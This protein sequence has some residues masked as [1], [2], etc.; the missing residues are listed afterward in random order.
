MADLSTY[1]G[2]C[3]AVA[4]WLGRRDLSEQIPTF[5]QLAERRMNRELRLR[6]M[7]RRAETEVSAGQQAVALPLRREAGAWDVFLEMRDLVW[8]DSDGRTHDLRYQPPDAYAVSREPGR[9]L[10]YSIVGRELFLIPAPDAAGSLLMSYYAELEPLGEQTP[11]N[12]LLRQ[13]PDIYLY[14]ALMEAVPYTRGSAPA[15]LWAQFYGGARQRLEASE[16][17][18]RFTSN[19]TMKPVRRI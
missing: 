1:S 10:G 17:R 8:R 13:A 9:P 16:Q 18:A 15:D 3:S 4:D 19:L 6:C 14:G 11:D 12:E 5:I 2:L 7:E